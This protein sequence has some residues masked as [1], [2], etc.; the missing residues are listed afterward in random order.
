M[1]NSIG[2]LSPFVSSDEHLIFYA[3]DNDRGQLSVVD[4]DSGE[5]I[6]SLSPD[7][8][9]ECHVLLPVAFAAYKDHLYLATLNCVHSFQA[10]WGQ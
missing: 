7:F 5:T 9:G 6:L 1:E 10:S 2:M 4:I 3:S 8:P